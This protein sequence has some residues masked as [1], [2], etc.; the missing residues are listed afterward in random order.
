MVVERGRLGE[1]PCAITLAEEIEELREVVGGLGRE[2]RGR[3]EQL[4]KLK[5][6]A[7]QTVSWEVSESE[8]Q[9]EHERLQA[10]YA[11]LMRTLEGT[12]E[13]NRRLVERL[14]RY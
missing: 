11:N 6:K 13:T 10:E 5:V 1:I 12:N 8:E 9:A 3:L 14:T 7:G 2:N 4:R